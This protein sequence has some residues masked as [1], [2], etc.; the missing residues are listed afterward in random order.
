MIK[1]PDEFD[2]TSERGRIEGYDMGGG[3]A[4]LYAD[5]TREGVYRVPLDTH[6]ESEVGEIRFQ[7]I[8]WDRPSLGPISTKHLLPA[9]DYL[10]SQLLPGGPSRP[11]TS[12][13]QLGPDNILG[14]AIGTKEIEDYDTG[15]P[16]IKVYVETKASLG[17]V[18]AHSRVPQEVFGVSTDVV[19]TEGFYSSALQNPNFSASTGGRGPIQ[20]GVSIGHYRGQTG[21][22]SCIVRIGDSFYI[23]GNYHVLANMGQCSIG[24]PI[25]HP[26]LADGGVAPNDTI[27][28]L[29]A[30]IHVITG[31]PWNY[32]DCALARI[33]P[34][35]VDPQNRCFGHLASTTAV[36]QAGMAVKKCGRSTNATRDKITGIRAAVRVGYGSKGRARFRGQVIIGSQPQKR[37]GRSPI[38]PLPFAAR[39]DSGS[40]VV[41]DGGNEPVA[42]IFAVAGNGRFAIAHPI[43][44]V[45]TKFGA[46]IV[47]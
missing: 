7:H 32:L 41:T 16:T 24:D 9:R 17:L 20:G 31:G 5:D 12:H 33:P 8:H 22:M 6:Q 39:G 11:R 43:D 45:L 38:P 35:D 3:V 10:E 36:A 30:Y 44:S 26:G 46:T 23:L 47:T 28:N 37:P 25:I 19:E 2:V 40:L 34:E 15:E 1:D 13:G 29:S 4:E 42:L 14:V 21:T 27:A 18:E